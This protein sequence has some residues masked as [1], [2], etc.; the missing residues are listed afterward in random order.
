V[1]RFTQSIGCVA[2]YLAYTLAGRSLL[3]IAGF[4]VNIYPARLHVIPS[5]NGIASLLLSWRFNRSRHSPLPGRLPWL[6]FCRMLPFTDFSGPSHSKPPDSCTSNNDCG[7]CPAVALV[8][9]ARRHGVEEHGTMLRPA[10]G[11]LRIGQTT[12]S[13]EVRT[14]TRQTIDLVL[15]SI[16]CGAEIYF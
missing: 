5:S 12:T 11:N 9:S 4:L 7:V 16:H 15:N 14:F 3:G 8:V 1:G 6:R 13:A 10:F 2:C